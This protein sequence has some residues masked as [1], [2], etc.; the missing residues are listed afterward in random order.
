[1]AAATSLSGST[2]TF[3]WV[4]ASHSNCRSTNGVPCQWV[5]GCLRWALWLKASHWPGW[6]FVRTAL[7]SEIPPSSHFLQGVRAGSHLKALHTF[8]GSLPSIFHSIS[9]NTPIAYLIPSWKLLIGGQKKKK[10]R[11]QG[12]TVVDCHIND[13]NVL[14]LSVVTDVD[15]LIMLSYVVPLC[16]DQGCWGKHSNRTYIK[17]FILR[18]WIGLCWQ[19]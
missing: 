10:Y 1:M 18:N 15:Y 12:Q 4:H 2:T 3:M 13:P 11:V 17:Q 19:G 16:I 7:Q 14:C 8:S 9:P 6:T 5:L